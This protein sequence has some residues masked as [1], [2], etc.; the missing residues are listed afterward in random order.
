MK[1]QQINPDNNITNTPQFKAA[2]GVFRYLA[3][4]QAVGANSVDVASMVAPRT[5]TDF[6]KRGPVAGLETFRREI[7]GTVNDSLLGG[8]GMVAGSLIALAMGF[9]KKFGVKANSILAAPETVNILAELKTKQLK[10]NKS[11]LDYFKDILNSIKSYN[12]SSAN[13]DKDGF[14][15]LSEETVNKVASIMDKVVSDKDISARTWGKKNTVESRHVVKNMIIGD[16]GAESKIVLNSL[17][18]KIKSETNLE[19]LLEDTFK[20]SKAF[21]KKQVREAF[22]EQIAAGKGIM[23]NKFIK[24][25]AKFGKSKSLAGFAVAAAVGLSV[26]PLN[27]YLTKKKTGIDGFVGV[28]GRTK[29]SSAGFFGLKLASTAAFFSMVMTTLNSEIKGIKKL[30]PQNFMKKMAFKGFWPTVNQLKGVYGLTI[31]SRL[32]SARDKDEL[33]ESFTKD[34]CG[35]LS[36]LVLSDIVNRITAEAM[37]KSVMNRTKETAESKN[38]FKRAFN[39]KLKTRDE[40]LVETLAKQGI[41]LTKE[42]KGKTVTKTFKDMLKDL[43]NLDN[44]EL[45]KATKKHLR[46]LNLAQLSGYLFSGLV[47]GFGI[48][49]LNIYITNTLDK[50]RK[51]EAAKKEA[52]TEQTEVSEA[53]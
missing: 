44:Q 53:A 52:Q 49:R 39:S 29:D 37:D 24:R 41:S 11:Q 18:G 12:P 6:A 9:N 21:N 50:K 38:F 48:P 43:K 46:T 28:E 1:V 34:F 36:W 5:I 20:L 16:T 33:R 31:I 2:D 42:Q 4:N 32:M 15:K 45:K 7:M 19:S 14:V 25:F 51:A 22:D 30:L 3:T 10:E 13:A 23:D 35:F 27:M 8:Y 17:D 47:L 40:I 26:Q